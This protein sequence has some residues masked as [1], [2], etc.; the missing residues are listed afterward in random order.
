MEPNSIERTSE[1]ESETRN[2]EQWLKEVRKH[3]NRA[4]REFARATEERKPELRAQVVNRELEAIEYQAW[5]I[6]NI[7]GIPRK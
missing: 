2:V 7:L 4:L 1:R 6:R 3:A 5:V